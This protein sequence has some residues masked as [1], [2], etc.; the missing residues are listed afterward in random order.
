MAGRVQG[1]VAFI[2]GAARGQG[3]SHAVRLAEEGADIIAVDICAPI[4]TVPYPLGTEEDLAE[5]VRLV[6]NLDRRIISKKVDIRDLD[7]LRTVAAEGVAAFGKIDVVVAN[8]GIAYIEEWQ[9]ITP[10]MWQDTIDVNLTGTWN[11]VMALAPH[12]VEAGGGSIILISSAAAQ[13]AQPFLVPY[14]A[15]K[16]GVLGLTKSFA[17]ELSDDNVRVNTILPTGVNTPMGGGEA[18]GT[19]FAKLLAKKPRLGTIFANMLPVTVVEPVDISNAVVYLASD[20]SR[21]VTASSMMVD[22]GLNQM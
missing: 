4:G 19:M 3:R 9:E 7:G 5:T 13:K 18:G 1:K 20:E 11:T 17:M 12:V 14:T 8:A 6:E 21:Y 22:A 10:Q 2:T 15:S 16:H